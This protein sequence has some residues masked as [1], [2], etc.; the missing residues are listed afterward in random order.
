MRILMIN[1]H[2]RARSWLRAGALA[3]RLAARGHAVTL[4]VLAD[5]ARWRF[6]RSRVRGIDL[7]ESPDLM[8]GRARSGWDPVCALR[9][10]IWLR[11]ENV[12]YD[13]IH[14]FETRP[15]TIY[16]GLRVTHRLGVPLVIDW[17]DWWGRGGTITVNRPLWFRYLCGWIET[18]FEEHFRAYADATTV[19][20]H[21][22]K[23]RA[24]RLG[25]PSESI[26]HLRPGVDLDQFRPMDMAEIRR[27][28][29]YDPKAFLIGF[30]SMDTFIDLPVLIE[31]IRRFADR[32][33][34]ARFL[35]TG[36][37]T[38]K[39][40]GALR[41]GRL[42][43]RVHLTG[44]VAQEEYPEHLA[45]CDVLAMPFPETNYNIGRWPNKFGEYLAIG[46]PVV[47]NPNGDLAKFAQGEIPGIACDY[48]PQ[49]F[50]DAIARLY[51]DSGLR[52]RT[53]KVARQIA[54]ETFVWDDVIDR[55]EALYASLTEGS[56]EPRRWHQSMETRTG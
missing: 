20:S 28:H 53:G 14:L 18:F 21:G 35:I 3:S 54:C 26:L 52:A 29:G 13:L 48:T 27:R 44:F 7:V 42:L 56:V 47:F 15:A 51:D 50:A 17:I 36:R 16:P 12:H 34:D 8:V 46:R 33:R 23:H 41:E 25:I 40:Q 55:L 1:H 9:R 6:R 10:H 38:P 30:A 22:L 31:G 49:A 32:R 11:R 39:L 24:E 45:A 37:V 4:M 19:I 43:D 2:R 5:T